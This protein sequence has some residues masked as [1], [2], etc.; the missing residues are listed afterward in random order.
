MTPWQSGRRHSGYTKPEPIIIPVSDGY[1]LFRRQNTVHFRNEEQC[2]VRACRK[3]QI[4][5]NLAICSDHFQSGAPVFDQFDVDFAPIATWNPRQIQLYRDTVWRIAFRFHK[6]MLFFPRPPPKLFI[7]TIWCMKTTDYAVTFQPLSKNRLTQKWGIWKGLIK[8]VKTWNN[9]W[10]WSCFLKISR[11][12]P[13]NSISWREFRRYNVRRPLYAYYYQRGTTAS[14]S[15]AYI[16]CYKLV[17][18]VTSRV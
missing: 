16:C 1:F 17:C 11:S 4:T 8:R 5:E 15:L 2:G 13:Q 7:L 18:T 3:D 12:F 6:T 14:P 10:S 9:W